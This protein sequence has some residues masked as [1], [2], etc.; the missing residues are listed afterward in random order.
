MPLSARAVPELSTSNSAVDRSWKRGE[1]SIV[2]KVSE[3]EK[4]RRGTSKE[5]RGSVNAHG[6]TGAYAWHIRGH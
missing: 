5:R 4:A 3:G 1:G 2:S 6:E